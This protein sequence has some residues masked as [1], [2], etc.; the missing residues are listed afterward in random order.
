MYSY[1][2]YKAMHRILQYLI[3]SLVQ[4]FRLGTA[5]AVLLHTHSTACFIVAVQ[6]MFKRSVQQ[7]Y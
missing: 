1:R 2:S 7:Y 5:A 3:E 6:Y 4:E